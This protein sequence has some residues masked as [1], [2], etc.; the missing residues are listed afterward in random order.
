MADSL[1]NQALAIV[2]AHT[3][4]QHPV[5]GGEGIPLSPEQSLVHT[6]Y[7]V[8][9]GAA[10]GWNPQSDIDRYSK[11]ARRAGIDQAEIDAA[12]EATREE[13]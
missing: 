3:A 9:Q 8:T 7:V 12:I 2:E 13:G 6:V 11:L 4:R 5:M 10:R 1:I